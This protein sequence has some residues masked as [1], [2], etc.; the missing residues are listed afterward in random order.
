MK[1]SFYS[2]SYAT[3][4]NNPYFTRMAGL[5]NLAFDETFLEDRLGY[6]LGSYITDEFKKSRN[7]LGDTCTDFVSNQWLASQSIY[8]NSVLSLSRDSLSFLA[9]RV[10][11]DH[12]SISLGEFITIQQLYLSIRRLSS[13]VFWRMTKMHDHLHTIQRIYTRRNI[14]RK[15]EDGS[16]AYPPQSDKVNLGGA[17]I[18]FRNITFKYPGTDKMRSQTCPSRLSQ[19]RWS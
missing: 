16:T 9:L 19:A 3:F 4:C 8:F 18:E 11:W 5:N 10:L 13:S 2:M 1:G 17:K 14:Q 15:V 12:N 6:D 7:L